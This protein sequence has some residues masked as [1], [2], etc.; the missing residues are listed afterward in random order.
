MKHKKGITIIELLVVLIAGSI[1]LIGVNAITSI[2]NRSN[3]RVLEEA[4]IYNDISLAFKLMQSRIHGSYSVSTNG[5]VLQAGTK[6]FKVYQHT[7]SSDLVYYPNWGNPGAN[8]VIFSMPTADMYQGSHLA[9]N[10][11]VDNSTREVTLSLVGAKVINERTKD[12]WIPKREIPFS[13][14]TKV[15]SRRK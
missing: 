9:F 8:Q 14:G 11:N 4:S 2:G 10:S 13:V 15:Y 6:Q 3:R 1:M 12:G 7:R 5:A